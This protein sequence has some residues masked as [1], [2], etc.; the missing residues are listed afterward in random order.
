MLKT[1]VMSNNRILSYS[2]IVWKVN[3]LTNP[4]GPLAHNCYHTLSSL[5]NYCLGFVFVICIFLGP[6]Q[7][8]T[9][10]NLNEAPWNMQQSCSNYMFSHIWFLTCQPLI[11]WIQ[12]K[13]MICLSQ[14]FVDNDSSFFV[15]FL[16]KLLH[17]NCPCFE[18]NEVTHLPSLPSPP[19]FDWGI[20]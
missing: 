11:A 14:V 13:F 6:K 2:S 3:F 1:I 16:F 9:S 15:I 4:C 20:N 17:L 10:R 19:Q 18:N 8:I 5:T 7:S 12:S